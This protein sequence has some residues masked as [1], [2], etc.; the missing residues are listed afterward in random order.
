[1]NKPIYLKLTESAALTQ[2]E[3]NEKYGTRLL[4]G[5]YLGGNKYTPILLSNSNNVFKKNTEYEVIFDYEI[6]SKNSDGFEVLFYSPSAGSKGIWLK[7]TII[8][9]TQGDH[10]QSSLRVKLGDFEDYQLRWN[11]VGSGTILLDNISVKDVGSGNLVLTEDFE[12]HGIVFSKPRI[13]YLLNFMEDGILVADKET[14]KEVLVPF[15][16]A[17]EINGNIKYSKNI[18]KA[19]EQIESHVESY[20]E[21]EDLVAAPADFIR[22]GIQGG[23]DV[24]KK[25]IVSYVNATEFTKIGLGDAAF[26]PEWDKDN[27][28]LID[29]TISGL[30]EYV[31]ANVLNKPWKQYVAK[32]WTEAWRD[33]LKGRIDRA[34][35]QNFDGIMLDVMTGYWTWREAY[36]EISLDDLRFKIADLFRWISK[37]AKSTYGSSFLVTANID[38]EAFLYF[39][40]LADYIDVGYYQNAFFNWNGNGEIKKISN[41]SLVFLQQQGLPLLSLEHLSSGD[42]FKELNFNSF[43]ETLTKNNFFRLFE[44]SIDS[45][46]TPY[47]APVSM[48]TPYVKTPHFVRLVGDSSDFSLTDQDG[49][50]IGNDFNNHINVGLGDDVIAGLGGNDSING[51][52]GIDLVYFRGP[53][54]DYLIKAATGSTFTVTDIRTV[55]DGADSLDEVERLRFSDTAVGLDIN[56]NSGKV[57]RVYK[58]TF[59]RNPVFG[60][61]AGLGYWINQIDNGMDMVEVAARFIDSPEFRTLYGQNPSHAD[62]L[63]KVYSNVLGRTPDQGGYSWWLNEL[64]TNTTK[65]KAKVLADFAESQENKDSVATL[66]GTGIQYTEFVG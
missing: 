50:V 66:I 33:V 47:L 57:F 36:P 34:A 16:T 39:P 51:G 29:K 54:S 38:H 60:D 45:G 23:N 24:E 42:G 28:Y 14:S 40:D 6:I 4:R 17:F 27:D 1:M 58:A 13:A 2:A 19:I 20:A 15:N 52:V 26:F 55:R 43:N 8:F 21:Y 37:Y 9:G 56:G 22:T 25:I 63:T 18:K 30:P 48:G 46:L 53:S 32:Y 59:A 35:N 41:D 61:K 5:E 62:F 12:P 10:G 31:D 3:S 65:T 44:F 11:I 64:N 49:Y 7:S